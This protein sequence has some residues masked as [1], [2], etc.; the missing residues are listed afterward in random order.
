MGGMVIETPRLGLVSLPADLMRAVL[1]GDL[2]RADALAP[3]PID[4][5]TFASADHVL[6]LRVAQ[7]EQD[8]GQLAWLLRA[9]VARNTG[10]FVARGGFHA[11]PDDKGTVEIGYEVAPRERRQGY[12]RETV[13]GLLRWAQEYGAV[14][15]RAS[16]RP[17]N[18]ASLALTEGLGFVRTGEQID[19]IDGLE[20][21]FTLP[22]DG[23]LPAYDGRR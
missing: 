1:A 4:A 21:I 12:A 20:W 7:L 10:R 14:R 19:E 3:F 2:T 5:E 16:I 11:P 17:D 15:C 8:P 9:A 23:P 6:R 13:I 22:L 18:L